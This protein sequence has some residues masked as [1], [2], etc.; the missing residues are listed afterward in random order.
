MKIAP[1]RFVPLLLAPL[2]SCAIDFSTDVQ[3]AGNYVGA[4]TMKKITLGK[5]QEYVA[6]LLGNPS[7]KTSSN[8][9]VEIWRWG[10]SQKR[11][12]STHFIFIFDGDS[13]SN[14]SGNAWVEFKDGRV[15]K[16]WLET[17]SD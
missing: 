7:S 5:S 8:E 17:F 3:R 13:E 6:A 10:F 15:V 14:M 1:S 4:E 12:T 16:S 11:E 9:G 2:S